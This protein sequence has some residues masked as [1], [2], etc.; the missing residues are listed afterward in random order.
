M[1]A[2]AGAPRNRRG[3]V[4]A[5]ASASAGSRP[6]WDRRAT[7]PGNGPGDVGAG[8]DW[9]PVPGRQGQ[10]PGEPVQAFQ[11][12]RSPGRRQAG[13]GEEGAQGADRG[14][15]GRFSLMAASSS[16]MPR[17]IESTPTATS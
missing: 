9:H 7:S 15:P 16:P 1:S 8:Q 12:A 14:R 6:I 5:A 11:E 13:I 3:Q 2:V 4:L 17:S 10:Q